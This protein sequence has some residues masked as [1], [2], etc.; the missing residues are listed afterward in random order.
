VRKLVA[1]E[2]VSLD[3]VMGSPEKWAFP[4]SNDEMEETNASGMAASDALLMGRVTF[5]A[6]AAYW[7]H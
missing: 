5:E 4:Y 7:P 1:S 3:D 2:I 6:L